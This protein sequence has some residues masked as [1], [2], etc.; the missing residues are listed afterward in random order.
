M[1]IF[2]SQNWAKVSGLSF[3][4]GRKGRNGAVIQIGFQRHDGPWGILGR[5]W[6]PKVGKIMFEKDESWIDRISPKNPD[7][8]GNI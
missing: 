4:K 1:L 6:F 3:T 2:I 5:A 8:K 7:K